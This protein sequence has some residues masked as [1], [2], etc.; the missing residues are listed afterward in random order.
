MNE[1][2]QFLQETN[3]AENEQVE[4]VDPANK[5]KQKLADIYKDKYEQWTNTDNASI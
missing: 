2:K 3:F 4:T 5:N 1:K